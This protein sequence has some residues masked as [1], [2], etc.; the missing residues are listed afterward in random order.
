MAVDSGQLNSV[1]FVSSGLTFNNVMNLIAHSVIRRCESGENHSNHAFFDRSCI[2]DFE[3]G[4]VG[5][6]SQCLAWCFL[7][8]L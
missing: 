3:L 7:H 4:F 2:T 8:I 5:S 6:P 1:N